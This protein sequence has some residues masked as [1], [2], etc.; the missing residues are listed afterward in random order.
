GSDEAHYREEVFQLETWCR[1]NNLCINVK[2][3]KEMIVD[4]RRNAAAMSP[5]YINGDMV[6]IVSCFKYLGVQIMDNF[7]W[8]SNTSYLLGKAHQRLY[9]L[10]RLKKA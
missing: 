1:V 7:T 10:R 2:K 9:F 8:T 6:E 5:L 3:T 4:F